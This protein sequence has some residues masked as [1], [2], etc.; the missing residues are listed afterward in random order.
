VRDGGGGACAVPG[1]QGRL[2]TGGAPISG[3]LERE[4]SGGH[5]AREP[6]RPSLTGD[7]RFDGDGVLLEEVA[8]DV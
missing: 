4:I 5:V 3:R 6:L 8:R 2:I 1:D 7:D